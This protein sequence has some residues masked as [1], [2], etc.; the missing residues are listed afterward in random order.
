MEKKEPSFTVGRNI[1]WYSH[2][3][4]VCWFLE[5]LKI[6]LPC[7]PAIPLLGVLIWRKWNS[8]LFL[9]FYCSSSCLHF[10]PTTCSLPHPSPPPT[11]E[12]TPFGFV[13]MSFIHVPWW[14]FPYYPL[15]SFSPLLSGY[16]QFVPFFNVSGRILLACLLC[17]LGSTYRWDR[18]VFV[19]HHLAYFT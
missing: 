17:W 6:E 9:F 14:S 12:P 3:E 4:T 18:M 15:L 10:H 2:Y 13:P 8:N 1:N 19:F 16:C 7:D 11:L 5:K